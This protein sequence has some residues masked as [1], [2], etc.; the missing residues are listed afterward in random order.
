MKLGELIE[1]L[2]N[3]NPNTIVKLGFDSPHSYRGFYEHLGFEL[4]KNVSIGVLLQ[5]CQEA[6]GSVYQGYKGGEYRS[7]VY[8]EVYLAK[9]SE[10][11]E[12]LG[13]LLL[14]YMLKDIE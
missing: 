12:E 8:T 13:K 2:K 4:R 10:T 6:L 3:H 9:Y 1:E 14:S 7:H 5:V 11:G